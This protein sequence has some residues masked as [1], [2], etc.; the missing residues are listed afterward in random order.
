MHHQKPITN[1][2]NIHLGYE[3]TSRMK[4]EA[5]HFSQTY[6]PRKRNR[7][8]IIIVIIYILGELTPAYFYYITMC[9]RKTTFT[10]RMDHPRVIGWY[11][12]GLLIKRKLDNLADSSNADSTSVAILFHM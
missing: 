4:S 10:C 3:Y 8:E 5:G 1:I 7:H 2:L 11:K 6:G 12:G 9:L